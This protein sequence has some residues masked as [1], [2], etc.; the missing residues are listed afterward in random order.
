M[1]LKTHMQSIDDNNSPNNDKILAF[2]LQDILNTI[3]STEFGRHSQC[4][5]NG[6]TDWRVLR[7]SSIACKTTF[8]RNVKRLGCRHCRL[9]R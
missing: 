6:Q 1:S 3:P 2:K 8:E 7:K 9:N 5:I 4:L